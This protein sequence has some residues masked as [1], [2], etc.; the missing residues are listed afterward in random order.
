MQPPNIWD[1]VQQQTNRINDLEVRVERAFGEVSGTLARLEGKMITEERLLRIL[2]RDRREEMTW[3]GREDDRYQG[4]RDYPAE[5]REER[6]L[7]YQAEQTRSY[8]TQIWLMILTLIMSPLVSI[9]T[10]HLLK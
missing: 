8:Q 10:T 2:D 6:S 9:I 5:R 4:L 1:T 3:R 7:H